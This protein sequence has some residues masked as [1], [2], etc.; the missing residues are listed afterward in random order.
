MIATNA[1]SQTGTVPYP[2]RMMSFGA[3]VISAAIGASVRSMSGDTVTFYSTITAASAVLIAIVGGFLVSRLVALSSEQTAIEQRLSLLTMERAARAVQSAILELEILDATRR[4]F[5]ELNAELFAAT[6]DVTS[7][8]I[9]IPSNAQPQYIASWSTELHEETNEVRQRVERIWPKS[10]LT[11]TVEELVTLGLDVN[12]IHPKVIEAVINQ[13]TKVKREETRSNAALHYLH[14][15]LMDL[16]PPLF[17]LSSPVFD[18]WRQDQDAL[19]EI[20]AT[21]R[22]RISELDSQITYANYEFDDLAAPKG[23]Y[24][25]LWALVALAATGVLLPLFLLL[26]NPVPASEITRTAVFVAF[27]A[28]LTVLLLFIWQQIR[29]VGRR[30]QASSTQEQDEFDKL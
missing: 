23:V 6:G 28:G 19:Y 2:E 30:D 1:S 9:D 16:G 12:N 17:K 29:L 25:G 13:I 11:T 3:T 22:V 15:P 8:M 24:R 4:R 26:L 7:D 20:L 18:I 21:H 27:I 14:S 10:H 5:F